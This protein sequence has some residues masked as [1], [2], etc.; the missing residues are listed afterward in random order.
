MA[1]RTTFLLL[2]AAIQ[3]LWLLRAV[4]ELKGNDF[5]IFYRSAA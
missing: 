4:P 2:L 3:W 1:R 5:G